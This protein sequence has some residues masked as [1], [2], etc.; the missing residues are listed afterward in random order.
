MNTKIFSDFGWRLL[1]SFEKYHQGEDGQL[2]VFSEDRFFNKLFQEF[3]Y[4]KITVCDFGSGLYSFLECVPRGVKKSGKSYSIRIPNWRRVL[5]GRA[6]PKIKMESY[7][8]MFDSRRFSFKSFSWVEAINMFDEEI[9]YL[10]ADCNF[11]R[12]FTDKDFMSGLDG[13][14]VGFFGRSNYT[15]T[16]I[17]IFNNLNRRLAG[18]GERIENFYSSEEI[19][20]LEFWT[21]CHVF[22]QA[23]VEYENE[24][25]F[26]N[27]S[28]SD[29][30]HPIAL[31]DF[32]KF[33]DHRKG[34]RKALEKSPEIRN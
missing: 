33:I 22:D 5:K 11:F 29:T 19:F 20:D 3:N 6:V 7:N 15:E 14:D 28:P 31:S 23:R 27:L 32:S 2:I 8:Y 34:P 16:G 30:P 12:D 18:F 26:K 10:D 13:G 9:V 25:N 17:L 21:D 24:L 4:E 1:D